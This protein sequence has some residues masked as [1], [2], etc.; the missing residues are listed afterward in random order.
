MDFVSQKAAMSIQVQ[1]TSLREA[2][3]DISQ[4]HEEDQS[5][6]GQPSQNEHTV[7][8]GEGV[9]WEEDAN[10]STHHH[11]EDKVTKAQ[12]SE[13]AGSHQEGEH[14]EDESKRNSYRKQSESMQEDA[15]VKGTTSEVDDQKGKD[16]ESANIQ[17]LVQ[18]SDNYGKSTP[19][20]HKADEDQAPV[21]PYRGRQHDVDQSASRR[22]SRSGSSCSP[23]GTELGPPAAAR[24]P[25]TPKSTVCVEAI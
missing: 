21:M 1:G 16:M 17:R 25:Q 6:N 23:L 18:L 11:K 15:N 7:T 3:R 9:Q 14:P 8:N 24:F 5:H 19:G 13:P 2:Q 22:S 4:L 10:L 20:T 12:G